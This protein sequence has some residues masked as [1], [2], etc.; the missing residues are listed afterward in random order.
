MTYGA[1]GFGFFRDSER[2]RQNVLYWHII[3]SST[4]LGF[5]C[6]GKPFQESI[7]YFTHGIDVQNQM[8]FAASAAALAKSRA[9][10]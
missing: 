7:E 4:E 6:P 1:V 8:V 3:P 10:A 9:P 5:H 2:F